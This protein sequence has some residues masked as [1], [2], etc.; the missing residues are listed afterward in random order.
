MSPLP[1]IY[2]CRGK[3]NSVSAPP[4]PLPAGHS[5]VALAEVR[6]LS[7]PLDDFLPTGALLLLLHFAQRIGF[8]DS[9]QQ[10]LQ[11]PLKSVLYTPLQKL[12][13]LIC[14]L[15]VGC[16]WNKDINFKLRPYSQAAR[17]LGMKRFPDQSSINRFLHRF[18]SPQRQQLEL[19]LQ[20]LLQR[21]GLWRQCARLD[22]D[23]DSTGLIVFGKTYQG[24]SKGYFPRQ[25]GR[26]GYRLA[27]TSTTTPGGLEILNAFVDP[28]HLSPAARFFDCL[29]ETAELLGSLDRIGL[30]RGDAS[31]GSG[32]IIETLIDL[33]VSFLIKGVS[34]QTAK[35]FAAQVAPSAWRPLD[36][37]TRL[38]DIGPQSISNCRHPVRVVLVELMTRRLD[39]PYYSHLYTS[40]S[41]QEADE[42]AL[43]VRYNDRQQ[44]EALFKSAKYGIFIK[45]LRTRNFFPIQ[46]FS[47]LACITFNLLCWFRHYFLAQ[48]GLQHLGLCEMARHLM[49]IPAQ[50]HHHGNQ[51]NL[52]FPENHPYTPALCKL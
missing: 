26:H 43:F 35:K 17:F 46:C 16:H 27:I 1:A 36:F 51:L 28:A 4:A 11:I 48:A 52:L 12:Q 38:C 15:A 5:P 41:A 9:F 2:L 21:F 24:A 25:R 42:E 14:S 31:F 3:K 19:I 40:L 49:D 33:G 10:H 7:A 18:G 44:I 47:L 39:R 37:F 23:I 8:F 30:V 29:Y 34:P 32:P 50:I 22:L 6:C 13:T 20:L 45:H